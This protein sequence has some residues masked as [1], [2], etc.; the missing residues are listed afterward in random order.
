M[1]AD[2]GEVSIAS[3]EGFF[4]LNYMVRC[5]GCLLLLVIH[6]QS[7]RINVVKLSKMSKARFVSCVIES[8]V[9]PM[10]QVVCPNLH[11]Q[12]QGN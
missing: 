3:I 1:S 4:P 9:S 7:I 10:D 12:L 5:D 8:W 11:A 2:V 6:D